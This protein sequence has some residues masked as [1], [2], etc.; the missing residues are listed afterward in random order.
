MRVI[1]DFNE[2]ELGKLKGCQSDCSLEKV[3]N[4]QISKMTGPGLG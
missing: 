1:K 4:N 3:A 2:V